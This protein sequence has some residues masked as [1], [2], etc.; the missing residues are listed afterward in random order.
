MAEHTAATEV[1]REVVINGVTYRRETDAVEAT[2]N[3]I[4]EYKRIAQEA[5]VSL[6]V[7]VWF[8]DD[9]QRQGTPFPTY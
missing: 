5:G 6:A 2:I 3:R 4:N 8:H 1:P 9:G 7:A